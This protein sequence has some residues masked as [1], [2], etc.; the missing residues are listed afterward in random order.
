M[1]APGS[2]S[3]YLAAAFTSHPYNWRVAVLSSFYWR[4]VGDV[5]QVQH[6]IIIFQTI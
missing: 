6:L 3:S 5:K 1:E 4:T 2:L